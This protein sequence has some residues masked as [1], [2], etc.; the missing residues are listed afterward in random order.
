MAV[1]RWLLHE[2]RMNATIVGGL[3]RQEKMVTSIELL[4]PHPDAYDRLAKIVKLHVPDDVLIRPKQDG[5][6]LNARRGFAPF[7]KEAHFEL[8]RFDATPMGCPGLSPD[9]IPMRVFRYDHGADGNEGW[10]TLIRTGPNDYGRACLWHWSRVSKGGRSEGGYPVTADNRRLPCPTEA[11][12]YRLL[13]LDHTDP[14]HRHPDQIPG[15][16]AMNI[17]MQPTPETA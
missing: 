11:E 14:K 1:A 13:Q 2:L 16:A 6:F 7:F 12:A 15:W 3:R 5:R 8:D 17:K 9:L 10:A 4:T